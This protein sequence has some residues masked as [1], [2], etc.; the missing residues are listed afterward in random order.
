M[1]KPIEL[2][3]EESA[4]LKGEA[5]PATSSVLISNSKY[6]N[7][8]LFRDVY[9]QMGLKRDDYDLP[10]AYL[11]PELSRAFGE[12]TDYGRVFE[13]LEKE[14]ARIPEF[15]DWL[16]ARYLS[17]FTAEMVADCAP[18]TLGEMIH[19]FIADS[20]LAI[21]FMYKDPPENDYDYLVKRRVQNHDIEHMVTGLDA[22]PVGE[23]ALVV[24]NS[25]AVSNYFEAGFAHELNAYGAILVA[26]GTSRAALHYPAVL[27]TMYEGIAR[28]HA[29]GDKQKKPLF[30]IRWEDY[31][32][33]QVDDIREE[34]SFEDGPEKGSWDW[35]FDAFRG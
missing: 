10:A 23:M 28:G 6:L 27:P 9:A 15:A 4:Y 13:A 32:D 35:T 31:L 29:L 5:E 30:M 21:D 33:W 18:G 20:G 11:V 26:T 2:N 25:M 16:D 3:K 17:S 12:V 7:N 22:S 8:P 24:A 34:F 14:K 1:N 19:G